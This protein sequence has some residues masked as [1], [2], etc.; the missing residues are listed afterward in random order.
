M[1][2][3]A[4][5]AESPWRTGLVGRVGPC[6]AMMVPDSWS[7]PRRFDVVL[8]D[9]VAALRRSTMYDGLPGPDGTSRTFATASDTAGEQWMDL[10]INEVR[11]RHGRCDPMR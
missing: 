7:A 4:P 3:Q 5:R 9:S 8:V 1:R 2:I 11:R 6:L 10:P